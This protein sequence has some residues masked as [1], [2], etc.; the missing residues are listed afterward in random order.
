MCAS[1]TARAPARSGASCIR[2]ARNT[3]WWSHLGWRTKATAAGGR[4]WSS[5][6]R[7]VV[8]GAMDL[9]LIRHAQAVDGSGVRD[10]ERPLTVKGRRD[11]LDVGASLLRHGVQLD[12]IAS[13][14]LVRAVETAELV[15]VSIG[16][17]GQLNITPSLSSERA[18]T[19]IQDWL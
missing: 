9:Y 11:A 6:G 4:R 5:S 14:P 2:Y 10:E 7:H 16:Y 1:S 12:V 3:G 15:A 19:Q 17:P 18:P 8:E 13:S